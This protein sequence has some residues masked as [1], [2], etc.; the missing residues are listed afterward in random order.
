[1]DMVDNRISNLHFQ[2]N[3]II[4]YLFKVQEIGCLASATK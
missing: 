1:M 3:H 2:Y 4:H